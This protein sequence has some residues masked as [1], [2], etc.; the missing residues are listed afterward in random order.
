VLQFE[1]VKRRLFAHALGLSAAAARWPVRAATPQ[2]SRR[3]LAVLLFDSAQAWE[4][5]EPELR[6]ELAALG[7]IDGSNLALEWH[8]AQG[9]PARLTQL[10]RQIASAGVDAVLTRGTPATRALQHATRTVPILTGVGD[11]VGAGFAKSLADPGGNI[12]GLSFAAVEIGRKQVELLRSVVPGLARLIFVLTNDRSL[13]VQDLMT[14]MSVGPRELGLSHEVALITSIAD[15]RR[16]WQPQGRTRAAVVS[17]LGK[18]V[19]PEE[20]ARLA[21]QLKMPTVFEYSFYVDVGGLMSYRL[22]WENQTRRTAVQ[23]DK[24]FKGIKP[25]QIPFELPTQSELVVNRST[26]RELGLQI[27]QAL[28]VRANRLVD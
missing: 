19:A 18:S 3:R 25:A 4:W 21:L 9:D 13:Y 1:L 10:A 27:P 8:F 7:W 17:G 26:A 12:S 16:A 23:L 22:N 24:I 14:S 6:Q 2:S 20:L 15:L 5:F 11:P 28:L